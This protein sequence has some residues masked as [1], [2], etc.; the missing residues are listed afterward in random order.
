MLTVG[1]LKE[2]L[3]DVPDNT[4]VVIH[5]DS[6]GGRAYEVYMGKHITETEKAPYDGNGL[7]EVCIGQ[8]GGVLVLSDWKI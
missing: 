7:I 2:I 8:A 1:K 5:L 6:K 3:K 4:E